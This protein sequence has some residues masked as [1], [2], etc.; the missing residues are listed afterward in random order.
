MRLM[1]LEEWKES[2]NLKNNMTLNQ[3]IEIRQRI[4][5]VMKYYG[6]LL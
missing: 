1:L 2:I 3:E 4:V 6:H 5:N